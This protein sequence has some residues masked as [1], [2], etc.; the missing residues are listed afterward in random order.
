MDPLLIPLLSFLGSLGFAMLI[1]STA[2]AESETDAALRALS[3]ITEEEGAMLKRAEAKKSEAK[4][5]EAQ[6][7][8]TQLLV[9]LLTGD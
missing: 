4:D 5:A 1:F 3:R 2:G 9:A 6:S 7:T 8:S